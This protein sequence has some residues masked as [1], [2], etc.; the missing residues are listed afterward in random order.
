VTSPPPRWEIASPARIVHSLV[1]VVL[2]GSTFVLGFGVIGPMLGLDMS[3][4][5]SGSKL[6][7]LTTAIMGVYSVVGVVGLG[8]FVFG[9]VRPSDIGWRSEHVARD[10]GTG[11]LGALCLV[12]CMLAILLLFGLDVDELLHS[13]TQ[14][15]RAQRAQML[16]IGVIAGLGEESVFRGYLQPALCSRLGAVIG[17]LAGSTIFALYHVVVTPH[18]IGISAKFSFGIVLGVLRY[19]TGSL[20]PAAIAHFTFWQIMGFA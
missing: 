14:F 4:V 9:R 18:V 11:L 19:R 12:G 17:I 5:F 13:I 20:W 6:A 10:I 2:M 1:L 8:L 3:E 7:L 15:T 16:L